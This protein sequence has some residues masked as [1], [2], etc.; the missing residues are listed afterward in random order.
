M[1]SDQNDRI[2]NLER[3]LYSR[4]AKPITEIKR[5]ELTQHEKLQG[6]GWKEELEPYAQSTEQEVKKNSFVNNFFIAAI[7]FFLAATAI[8]AYV[9]LG[10]FNVISTKNVDISIQGLV[11]VNAGEELSLDVIVRNNNNS[12]LEEATLYIEYPEGTRS[13]D[14]LT[15]DITRQQIDLGTINSGASKT[16]T[17]KAVFFGQ[18]D[19][20]K[21]VKTRIDYKT[22]GSNAFFT[23]EKN[24]DITIKSAPLLMNVELPAEV[25]SG[26]E[27]TINIEVASNANA[28]I[29]DLA[30][31]A[32]YP[33]GF[34]FM[35]SN[36][37]P[38]SERNM[39]K[40]GDLASNEKRKI[41]IK[42]R[43]DGQSEEE[44]T[45]RFIAGTT[46]SL[47][48]RKIAIG[49]ITSQQTLAIKKP[50]IGL[51]L[52]LN[53][54]TGIQTIEA[55]GRV[56]GTL[57]WS[58]DLPIEINDATIEVKLSGSGLDRTQVSAGGGGFYRSSDN[59]IV[60]S[61]SSLSELANLD[62][63]E[64]GSV[65]FT[66]SAVRPT[67]QTLAQGRN[68]DINAVVTMFGTRVQEGV[69][70]QI[71]SSAT[72][73]AKIATEMLP[74]GKIV[75]SVGPFRNTGPVPP[76][77][78]KETTYTVVWGLSNSFND[79][80]NATMKATLPPYVRWAG[81]YNPTGEQVSYDSSSRTVTWSVPDLRA[82][83]G[84][85]SSAKEVSFQIALLPSVNQVG[86]SPDLIG[87]ATVQ[88]TDRFTG[89]MVEKRVSA[90]NTRITEDPSYDAGDEQVRR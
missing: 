2:D 74:T 84:Y 51:S 66:L 30:V 50:F 14:D 29:Q 17:I 80:A 39:W 78:D 48:D 35:S 4:D 32:E 8:A 47:D 7:I 22:Y 38:S 57:R 56:T 40:I 71:S 83:V 12:N 49:Y 68:M 85:T 1:A 61:R 6:Y 88:G 65:S 41:Q 11:A 53:G 87:S 23:K 5:P 72:G 27:I 19:S 34:T 28:H 59:T 46:D 13:I 90:L 55:G 24:F 10:G 58:N 62:P 82:G 79:V 18:K 67:T 52:D 3:D 54:K 26:Q 81:N 36:P 44:R 31:Q 60:W 73:Q 76:Q 16:E 86:S 33:F 43:M 89:S 69:P 25:N 77:V 21:Q 45:F 42:G 37:A 63:G 20:V 70:Q 15:K 64:N 75:Y 9:I